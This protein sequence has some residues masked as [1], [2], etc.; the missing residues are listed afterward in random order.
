MTSIVKWNNPRPDKRLLVLDIDLTLAEFGDLE[1][2][3]SKT[4]NMRKH[5]QFFLTMVYRYYD[6]V[7][8]S[9]TVMEYVMK[10]LTAM[11]MLENDNFKLLC[12]LDIT[13]MVRIKSM[14]YGMVKVSIAKLLLTF[15]INYFIG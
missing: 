2:I 12:A 1:P 3:T 4:S 9:G 10:K 5:M 7:I 6:I 14:M 15:F 13:Y 11:D 8:W